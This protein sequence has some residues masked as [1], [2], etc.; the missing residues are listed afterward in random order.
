MSDGSPGAVLCEDSSS[1][2]IQEWKGF[3]EVV[4]SISLPWA[5]P[6]KLCHP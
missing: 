6:I 2:G 3:G 5:G 4:K 1:M